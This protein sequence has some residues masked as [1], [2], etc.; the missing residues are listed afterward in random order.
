MSEIQK[1]MAEM[2]ER[3]KTLDESVRQFCTDRRFPEYCRLM[4]IRAINRELLDMAQKV[5]RTR[6]HFLSTRQLEPIEL[7]D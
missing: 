3:A 2:L 5:D 7:L 6:I 4:E 1:E